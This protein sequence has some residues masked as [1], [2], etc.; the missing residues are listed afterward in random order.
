M[1]EMLPQLKVKGKKLDTPFSFGVAIE[2]RLQPSTVAK[3]HAN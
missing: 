3:W 2:P 1:M